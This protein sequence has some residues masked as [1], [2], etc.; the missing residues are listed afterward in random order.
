M[1]SLL[2]S[3]QGLTEGIVFSLTIWVFAA[4]P[5][6]PLSHLRNALAVEADIARLCQLRMS[7]HKWSQPSMKIIV[8]ILKTLLGQSF[9]LLLSLPL[10]SGITDVAKVVAKLVLWSEPL[11]VLT[12]HGKVLWFALFN[13]SC[14]DF[15]WQIFVHIEEG[16]LVPP[17]LYKLTLIAPS[18]MRD[19]LH[20]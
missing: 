12:V 15:L 20:C 5:Q 9:I 13:K 17:N 19:D 8:W 11:H 2:L 18:S 16:V 1:A 14:P 4:L 6:G 10:F 7:T 3:L